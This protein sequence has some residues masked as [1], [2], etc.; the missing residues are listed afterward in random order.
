MRCL[1]VAGL[2]RDAVR[3]LLDASGARYTE[4]VVGA[5][6]RRTQGNPFFIVETLRLRSS[7]GLLDLGS[8]PSGVRQ[9]IRQ[10]VGLLPDPT[11]E[12]M[13]AA[14]VLGSELDLVVLA[15]MLGV[16]ATSVLRLLDPAFRAGLLSAD[17]RNPGRCQFAHGL[18]RDTV[19]EDL[20]AADRPDLHRRAAEA[21]ETI[22]GDSEGSTCWRWPTTGSTP[23]PQLHPTRVWLPRCAPRAGRSEHGAAS[24][25]ANIS[26]RRSRC[27][28]GMP[29]EGGGRSSTSR[30]SS[31]STPSFATSGYARPDVDL[32]CARMRELCGSIDDLTLLVPALWR[33]ATFHMIGNDLDAVVTVGHELLALAETTTDPRPRIAGHMMLGPVHTE[34][35]ELGV[36]RTHLDLAGDLCRA[37]YDHLVA[38]LVSRHRRCGSR[39][40]RRGTGR[41]WATRAGGARRA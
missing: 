29:E 14:S 17:R 19:Y 33:L 32:A 24:R 31:S 15:A 13:E 28:A 35:G 9:V 6:Q 18:V 40:C 21:L 7:D 11:V 27:L 8:V 3:E 1:D 30:S 5:L 23:C 38:G 4:D 10:R 22:H 25:R 12:A 20:G 39:R 2:D 36:A 26:K 16:E 34:R 41:W 37:G